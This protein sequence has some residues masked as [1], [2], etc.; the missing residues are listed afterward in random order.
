MKGRTGR[1]LIPSLML[2]ALL[3]T[4]TTGCLT[5]GRSMQP[6]KNK[7]TLD[8]KKMDS[9]AET[10]LIFGH[11]Y[12]GAFYG[13]AYFD[14]IEFSQINPENEAMWI[15][16]GTAG[17]MFYCTPVT[18]G[19]VLHMTLW[20]YSSGNTYYYARLGIGKSDD[21]LTFTAKKPGLQYVGAHNHKG[22]KMGEGL[23][24]GYTYAFEEEDS[25]DELDALAKLK[26]LLK[27]TAWEAVIDARIQE[28]S[29]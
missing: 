25:P 28:L 7:K 29:K 14:Q 16:P 20:G 1:R 2:I 6:I 9:P 18:P 13:K 26:P 4:V 27:G 19:S 12:R 3:A 24:S 21:S 10:T 17:T 11:I 23:L 5:N 15:F 22:T 8:K